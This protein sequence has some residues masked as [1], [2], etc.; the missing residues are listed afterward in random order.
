MSEQES[1]P[2]WT[3]E[4]YRPPC[5]E[6]SFCCPTWVPP[7]SRVPPHPDLAGGGG[8]P[9][10]GTPPPGYPPHPDLAGG[11]PDQG[12][13]PARVPP[14]PDLAGGGTWPGYPPA[15]VPPHPDLAG[16]TWPGT[17][18]AGYPPRPGYPP[19]LDLAG[20]PPAGPDPPL[21]P[22]WTWPTPPRLD[23]THPSPPAGPDPPLPPSW[24][25]PTPP[26]R[27][28]LT[29]PSPPGWTW[30]AP[31]PPPGV[32]WQTK[33]NYY[34][35]VVLR[36]RAVIICYNGGHNVSSGTTLLLI[37]RKC[38]ILSSKRFCLPIAALSQYYFQFY[39]ILIVYCNVNTK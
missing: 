31:P 23:L 20:Y 7:P 17:P 10:Q 19:R 13:P 30:P 5:S 21:P 4:A 12:T 36:T 15:R 28:D 11:V 39:N 16:G 38:Y 6:Y 26:P 33:W 2:A 8:V 9:D 25:W 1:P 14:H 22:S 32:D 34:L 35:P 3:Q 27:L 29:H 37:N 18:P 24:T